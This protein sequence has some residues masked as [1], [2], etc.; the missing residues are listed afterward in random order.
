MNTTTDN[1][2]L[3]LDARQR[4][5]LE[6]M[7]IHVW[8]PR[9]IEGKPSVVHVDTAQAA[10]KNAAITLSDTA[11]H[12]TS[13]DTATSA[14][15]SPFSAAPASSAAANPAAAASP[16]ALQPLPAG[17]A[18][19][20]WQQ[21][22]TA[23]S[24]CQACALCASRQNPVFGS[25]PVFNASTNTST[26]SSVNESTNASPNTPASESAIASP[27]APVNQLATDTTL[28][29][30]ADWLIVGEA[31]S[32]D[33]DNQGQPFVGQAGQLLDNMLRA[34]VVNGQP[35]GRQH[36]VFIANA[37]KCRPPASR[38]PSPQELAMCLP[39]LQRQIELLQPKVILAMG[40]FA[41]QLLTSSPE[42]LGKLRGRTHHLVTGIHT[43]PVIATYHPAYLLRTPADKAKAWGDLLLAMETVQN[44]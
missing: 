41:V 10:T 34:V 14:A 4:S 11:T 43:T 16:I 12:V 40:R 32:E 29:P 15:R 7:G 31:P 42:P 25:G 36:N 26:S 20:D 22:Q 44:A 28:T 9:E 33:E 39:Y 37:L 21:L 1:N 30:H 19:M 27:N 17:I 3:T 13:N 38:N 18:S 5:M 23:V 35:L 8:Q 24:S 2:A 6:A